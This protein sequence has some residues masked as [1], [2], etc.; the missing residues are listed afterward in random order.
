[1]RGALCRFNPV[2]WLSTGPR[3]SLLAAIR[4]YERSGYKRAVEDGV[5]REEYCNH[6]ACKTA[7]HGTGPLLGALSLGGLVWW[8][9]SRDGQ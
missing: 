2:R 3:E 7:W 1:M 5:L 4:A 6:L 8:Y 9:T